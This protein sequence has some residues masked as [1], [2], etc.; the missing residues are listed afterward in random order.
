MAFARF[1]SQAV[2]RIILMILGM[3]LIVLQFFVIGGAVGIIVGMTGFVPLVA[4]VV[5]VCL[6]GPLVGG[7]SDWRKNL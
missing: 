5:D 3:T 2:V 4:E 7:Y 6:I 1:M